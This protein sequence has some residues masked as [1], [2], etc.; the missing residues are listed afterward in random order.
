M[1][2]PARRHRH[3]G[4]Q[5]ARQ[6]RQQDREDL[7]Q[8]GGRPRSHRLSLAGP[9]AGA[10]RCRRRVGDRQAVHPEAQPRRRHDRPRSLAP[11]RRLGST[12]ELRRL[13]CALDAREVEWPEAVAVIRLLALIGCRRSEVLNLRWRDI[14]GHAINLADGKTGPPAVPL[15]EAAKARLDT[16]ANERSGDAFLF[17]RHAHGRGT[18]SLTVCWRAVCADADFD[19]LRLHDLRHTMASHAVRLGVNLSLVGRLLGHRRHGTTAG[20]AHLADSHLVEASEQGG[21]IIAEAV[22]GDA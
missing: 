3:C 10:D 2:R 17:P 4:D 22:T 11:S 9:G 12:S 20:Y 18:Y 16:L 14:G 7:R 6:G 21:S 13:G 1:D 19:G 15:G 8:D 5:D